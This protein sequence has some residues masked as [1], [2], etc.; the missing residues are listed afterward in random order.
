MAGRQLDI[1]L[2]HSTPYP[3]TTRPDHEQRQSVSQHQQ[4]EASNAL[5]PSPLALLPPPFSASK[6]PRHRLSAAEPKKG[7]SP[8]PKPT[9]RRP[10]PSSLFLLNPS[11]D[12]DGLGS[13]HSPSAS[14][15]RLPLS[16]G[17]PVQDRS[18]KLSSLRR[19]RSP[20]ASGNCLGLPASFET[21]KASPSR[22][23]IL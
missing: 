16:F 10:G 4:P 12:T 1:A 8:Q 22:L 15:L 18:N 11:K 17:R 9:L 13:S 21:S 6:R 23:F 3:S 5:R 14:H 19:P 7:H 2:P 20:L